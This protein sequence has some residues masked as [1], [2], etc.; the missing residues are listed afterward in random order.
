MNENIQKLIKDK[1]NIAGKVQNNPKKEKNRQKEIKR[2][3]DRILYEYVKKFTAD[4][5]PNLATNLDINYIKLKAEAKE[6]PRGAFLGYFRYMSLTC[7]RKWC[8]AH[9]W[10]YNEAAPMA[11]TNEKTMSSTINLWR[12]INDKTKLIIIGDAYEFDD[13]KLHLYKNKIGRIENN[14]DM[15]WMDKK[16][17]IPIVMES[18]LHKLH[19]DFPNINNNTDWSKIT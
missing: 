17:P 9:G 7:Q 1:K 3:N 8:K 12:S 4:P 14:Q 11:T 5:I 19:P 6:K 10:F 13:I 2:L 15:I 18:E 16:S